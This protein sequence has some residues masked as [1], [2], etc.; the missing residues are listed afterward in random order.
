MGKGFLTAGVCRSLKVRK[1]QKK[2][3]KNPNISI[4]KTA[5][6]T[7]GIWKVLK[8]GFFLPVHWLHSLKEIDF[9][10]RI[11]IYLFLVGN[12]LVQHVVQKL[13]FAILCDFWYTV[14]FLVPTSS[15]SLSTCH[16]HCQSVL[17]HSTCS[18]RSCPRRPPIILS[19][20]IS[21]VHL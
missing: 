12:A 15:S 20:P 3:K 18:C 5:V 21:T 7:C 8:T 14:T 9:G 1:K 6:C 19:A 13:Q 17:Q 11:W 10:C 2:K 16:S 4:K